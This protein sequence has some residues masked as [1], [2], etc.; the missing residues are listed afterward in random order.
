M[1]FSRQ[2]SH[3]RGLHIS[4]LK[5]DFTSFVLERNIHLGVETDLIAVS[6]HQN[7]PV[8]HQRAVRIVGQKQTM[9]GARLEED[10]VRPLE[11]LVYLAAI[12]N[13]LE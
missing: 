5:R 11:G 2:K 12:Q 10:F 3:V 9:S 1:G 6:L 8:L 13:L 4:I 7:L